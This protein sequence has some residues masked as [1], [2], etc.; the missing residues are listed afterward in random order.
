MDQTEIPIH[1]ILAAGIFLMDLLLAAV[2]LFV[3]QR[4]QHPLAFVI[5]AFLVVAGVFSAVLVY[6]NMNPGAAN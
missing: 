6:F 5:P 4:R 2:I 1:L 3:L